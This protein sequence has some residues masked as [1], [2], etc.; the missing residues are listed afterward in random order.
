[1]LQYRKMRDRAGENMA[2]YLVYFGSKVEEHN[3]DS[4]ESAKAYVEHRREPEHRQV[5][6]REFE[7]PYLTFCSQWKIQLDGHG[8][9]TLWR[10]V[11]PDYI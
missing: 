6:L 1:M 2:H 4:L 9:W 5:K 10:K 7:Y 8:E 11:T 3:F